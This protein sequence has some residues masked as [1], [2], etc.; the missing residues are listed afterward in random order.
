MKEKKE[1]KSENTY[2]EFEKEGY[3]HLVV[4]KEDKHLIVYIDK[5]MPLNVA[6]DSAFDIAIHLR[7]LYKKRIEDLIE[8]QKKDTD[9]G[10]NSTE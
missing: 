2:K 3:A 9:S 7:E 1:V 10:D 5:Q 4:T 6:F 8:Q